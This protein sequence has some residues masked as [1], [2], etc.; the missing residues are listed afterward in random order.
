MALCVGVVVWV[1]EGGW[2]SWLPMGWSGHHVLWC[3]GLDGFLGVVVVF[4]LGGCALVRLCVSCACVWPV[5]WGGCR[6]CALPLGCV[7]LGL[8]LFRASFSPVAFV[9]GDWVLTLFGVVGLCCRACGL[10]PGLLVFQGAGGAPFWDAPL[11][12]CALVSCR[13]LL[14]GACLALSCGLGVPCPLSRP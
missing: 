12:S 3:L 4:A 2:P 13:A 10:V 1:G 5:G 9:S 8:G 11:C 14:A 6:V 7:C